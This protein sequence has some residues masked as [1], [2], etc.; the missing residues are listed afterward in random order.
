MNHIKKRIWAVI[1]SMLLLGLGGCESES[2]ASWIRINQMGYQPEAIKVAVLGSLGSV[3]TDDFVIHDATTGK[4]LATLENVVPKGAWGP[5]HS[6]FRLDFTEFQETGSYYISAAGTR[7][8]EFAI[9]DDIYDDTADFLLKYM[10][11]QRCGFNPYLKDSCHTK[12]GFI[13]YHPELPDG[14]PIDVT[15]GWHDATDY[16]QYTTTSANALFHLLFAYRE[17]PEA[18]ADTH[19][20]NGI[21]GKNGVPD[22][23]DEA[24]FGLEWLLKMNPVP[25]A[26][27][28]Q[29]AD[30]RDHAGFRLP[31]Q[32]SVRY[33]PEF[34]GRPVYFVSGKPQG[35]FSYQN[36]TTG[37]ASTT[38]KFASTFALASEVLEPFGQVKINAL[39]ERAEDAFSTGLKKPGYMQTAPASAPYFYE[40]ETWADDMELAAAELFR[41]TG[42]SRYRDEALKFARQE[43]VTPWMGRD[44]ARH[45][46]FY[47]FLNMGHYEL[48]S[49]V[50]GP[51]LQEITNYYRDGLERIYQRGK[52][53]PFLIGVPFIW[54]SN[55]LV[56][57]ALTQANLYHKLTGDGRYGE[58]E[59]ALRDWL[60]GCNPWGTSMIVGLPEHGDSPELPHSSLNHLYGYQTDGGLVDGPVYGSIFNNLKGLTLF[61]EDPY[62]PFQSDLVVYHDDAGDYST[63]EPTMDGVA[64]LIYYLSSLHSEVGH[65]RIFEKDVTGAIRRGSRTG[66]QISLIFTGH[67]HAD[68]LKLITDVLNGHGLKGAFFFTGDFYRNEQY[69]V[70]IEEL[71]A[72]GHY[73]GAHSDRH[74]LYN[75]WKDRELL[76][77]ENEFKD[78]LMANY[79]KMVK[80]GISTND[81]RFFLPPYE[82]ND[83]TI[84][85]WTGDLGLTLINY[86]PGTLSHADYT[87][88]D[89]QN[90]RSSE[91]IFNSILEFEKKENL[92]GFLLLTHVGTDTKR[93]DKFYDRLEALIMELQSRGYTFV[94]LRKLLTD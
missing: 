62:A 63:N 14:T 2:D 51:E 56:A 47:P 48:A 74:L 27:Y 34:K 30:D 75:D 72:G 53:N 40:E 1:S 79:R 12:D 8:P 55:N 86:T 45:Y 19:L 76:V 68:G 50:Q 90:Y 88:P 29:I 82:W 44:T 36:R 58:M 70:L 42:E 4:A 35:L 15:G 89:D 87:L 94:P 32:D 59:A 46:Q 66:K 65:K 73:L 78:D 85:R 54:C 43:P 31:T 33:H 6:S 92:D 77:S 67:E 17:N 71:R 7:S 21:P 60:F 49:A 11:Q 13:I 91:K 24:H 83:S 23:I 3:I 69:K 38:G 37:V 41:Q 28:N 39:I 84:T 57:A 26:Y 81:A 5:F 64:S 18:F 9:A 25:G 52:D 22:V 16:L 80:F 20:A 10:R 61:N 93:F